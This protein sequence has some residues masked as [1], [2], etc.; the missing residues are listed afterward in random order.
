MRPY[1]NGRQHRSVPFMAEKFSAGLVP[2]LRRGLIIALGFLAVTACAADTNGFAVKFTSADGKTSDRMVLPNLWLYVE[3]GKSPTPFLPPGKFTAVFEGSI[4]G[5]LRASYTFKAE[6]LGGALKLEINNAMVLDTSAPGALSKPVQVNKG[7]NAVRA[8]FTSAGGD[9]F[10]RVGWTEKGTN[11][12][13][14]PNAVITHTSTPEL[15]HAETVYLGRE[16]FLEHRCANCHTEKFVSP[17][18][19]LAMDAPSF[20]GIGA[21]RNYRWMAEWILNPKATRA[22]VHMPKLLHGAK[23][24]EEAEA[25]ANYLGSL[26]T[27][28]GRAAMMK[29]ADLK[30][31]ITDL[32]LDQTTPPAKRKDTAID[33]ITKRS[34]VNAKAAGDGNEQPADQNQER[35][36]VFERF[37][38]ISCHNAP[39][40][41]E[42]D[43]AKISL[44]HVAQKFS[45]GKLVEFLKAPEQHFE[46]IR[47]PNFKLAGAEA[48]ELAEFL[49]KNADKRAPPQVLDKPLNVRRGQDLV[50]SAGCLNCHTATKQ[51]N[52][53]TAPGLA[54]LAKEAKGCLAEKRAAKSKAP[55]FA[56]NA[57][58][59]EALL[60]FVKT[61]F[62]SLSRHSP[63][64][65]A[66]RETR[67]LNC[68]ACHGV[69]DLI[70]AFDVLGGKLKPEWAAAFIGGEPF[71][72]RA[73]KHPKGELWV[74]ARMPAFRSRAKPLAEAMAMQQG[75]APKTRAEGSM[76][77]EAAKVG[78]KLVGMD[79]G[80]ACFN[81]HAVNDL[82]ALA[83]F[84]SEG[85]NLGLTRARLL[86]PY[87][88][89]WLRSPI[90]VDPGSKMPAYFEDGKSAL[91]DYYEGDAEKQI[92]ALY[93]YIRQ[94]EKMTAPAT[95]Q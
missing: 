86:K 57:R 21:R 51:E 24:R 61:D 84:E 37:H 90:A 48:K 79:G 27:Y 23:A 53:F 83:V 94:G 44:K 89:R 60:A 19:E 40:K 71:K 75:Y 39:D 88:F 59:R 42:N 70:P 50:Q 11:V 9:S 63:L 78:H 65:F 76:D 18:P 62:A 66:A 34:G 43:P 38:C 13:P 85:I 36:P 73:D 72:V 55:D 67:L 2:A 46:W 35:K 58:E 6:E 17:V 28:Q 92:N 95:G 1:V 22:S 25:I 87:F 49:L 82:S 41:T 52:K 4:N 47:M 32:D 14:I 26:N 3:G 54:K 80:L 74:E 5:D 77:E 16:L 45:D 29:V 20:D 81:C 33:E 31:V 56:F 7:A 64:E 91:T 93:Q 12:N 10:L 68:A 30:Y 8:T 69:V 15:Q